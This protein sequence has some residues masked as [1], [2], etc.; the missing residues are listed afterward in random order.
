M[1]SYLPFN[2]FYPKINL[3]TEAKYELQQYKQAQIC[4]RCL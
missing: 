1:M 4:L 3:K 2:H